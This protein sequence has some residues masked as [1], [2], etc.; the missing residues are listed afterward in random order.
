MF[1]FVMPHH[2]PHHMKTEFLPRRKQRRRSAVQSE[3]PKTGA[4]HTTSLNF[5]FR[6]WRDCG[7]I[8]NFV[9]EAESYRQVILVDTNVCF[10]MIW[11]NF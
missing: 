9:A 2:E 8:K 3:T 1:K 5:K 4:A 10:L 11:L 7:C 6:K